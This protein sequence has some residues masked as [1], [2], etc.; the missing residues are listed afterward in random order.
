MSIEIERKFVLSSIPEGLPKLKIKQG[1]L[2]SDKNRTV[3]VRSL[4]N[5]KNKSTYYITIKGPSNSSGMSR[6]EYESIISNNDA[7]KLFDLCYLPLIIKNRY[8]YMYDG[9]KW[10]LDSFCGDNKGLLIGEVEIVNE[11]IDFEKPKFVIKEVT[12]NS[13]YYNSMLQKNP[14]NNW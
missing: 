7:E 11:N 5:Q 10:E 12:G 3:R 13:K 1:Y 6:F 2:Q 9:M 8:I 14:Y 4:I